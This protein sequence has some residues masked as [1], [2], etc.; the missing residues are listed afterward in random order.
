MGGPCTALAAARGFTVETVDILPD[1]PARIAERA[2]HHLAQ[3]VELLV[4]V[5]GTGVYGRDQTV[6]AVHLPRAA[7]EEVTTE[8]PVAA[9]VPAAN[10]NAPAE[11]AAPKKDEKKK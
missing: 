8:A 3:G 5:G 4:T 1:E 11:A 7:V 10:Q 6:A 2:R 9:D